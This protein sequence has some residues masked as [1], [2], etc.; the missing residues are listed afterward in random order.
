MIAFV[1][2]TPTGKAYP[3]NGHG[4]YKEGD[5]VLVRWETQDRRLQVG[6][7][8]AT[9]W[10][11][12]PS[13]N[14][15]VCVES[16]AE[17]YGNGPYDVTTLQELQDFLKKEGWTYYK[18]VADDQSTT[19]KDMVRRWPHVWLQKECAFMSEQ[20]RLH[21]GPI[22]SSIRL[23]FSMPANLSTYLGTSSS[24]QSYDRVVDGKLRLGVGGYIHPSII[25]EGNEYQQAAVWAESQWLV[26]DISPPDE[27][28]SISELRSLSGD[29]DL[30]DDE[31]I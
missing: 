15:I 3:F 24:S 12:R 18:T 5:R 26:V 7:I 19:S 2:F 8:V 13:K 4:P 21:M 14:S 28:M 1:R 31:W 30:D 6:E 23:S 29:R 11:L 25:K 9:D 16:N 22:H 17:A 20:A 10:H 27:G